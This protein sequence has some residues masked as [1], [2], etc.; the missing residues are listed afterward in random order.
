MACRARGGW[1]SLALIA[2]PGRELKSARMAVRAVGPKRRES[3][4]TGLPGDQLAGSDQLLL[5]EPSQV[6]VPP[7]AAP[8]PQSSKAAGMNTAVRRRTRARAGISAP[9]TATPPAW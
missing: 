9:D 2:L 4:S 6:S 8:A 3:L 7:R 1:G 5:V